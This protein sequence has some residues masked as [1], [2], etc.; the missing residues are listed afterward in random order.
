MKLA[1]DNEERGL[2]TPLVGIL[3]LVKFAHVRSCRIR[4]FYAIAFVNVQLVI[5]KC[6]R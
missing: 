6:I 5:N 2:V 1:S 4:R 3:K